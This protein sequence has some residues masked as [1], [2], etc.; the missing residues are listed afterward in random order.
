MALTRTNPA[1]WGTGDKL[2]SGQAN[3]IDINVTSALDKRAGQTD[4]LSSVVTAT[5]AGRVI[6]TQVDGANADTTYGITAGNAV[7]RVTSAVTASRVYTLDNTIAVSG[8]TLDIYCD[9]TF[10]TFQVTVKN[11]AA[12]TIFL[13]G[14]ISSAQGPWAQFRFVGGAWFLFKSGGLTPPK[15]Q[16]A[17]FT[18]NGTFTVPSGVTSVQVTG[19]GGGGGGGG[20]GGSNSTAGCSGGGGGGAKISVVELTVTPL[21]AITV[22]LGLGGVVGTGGASAF[23]GV[24]G[25]DGGD[26]TFGALATFI[27][28][29][30]GQRGLVGNAGARQVWGGQPAR[31]AAAKVAPYNLAT[32]RIPGPGE[33]GMGF[34]N[35]GTTITAIERTGG[36]TSQALGATSPISFGAGSGGGGGASEWPANAPGAGGGDGGVGIAGGNG[37]AG[38]MG[39]GGGGGAGGDAGVV[40]GGNGGA[41]GLGALIVTYVA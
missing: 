2:T 17:T 24:D 27:G 15:M 33:G 11:A 23:S 31:S 40:G 35:A 21:A 12:A 10:V 8:D 36:S 29:M 32:N 13:L 16:T 41:G 6:P 5:G 25:G 38:T 22:T 3:A 19:M 39:A 4:T 28:A 18:T 37:A 1:T 30:G 34:N 20:G 26:T 9:A 14:N 7:I